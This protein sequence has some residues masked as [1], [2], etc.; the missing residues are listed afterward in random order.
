M[1]WLVVVYLNPQVMI[2]CIMLS[3]AML[4]GATASRWGLERDT[5]AISSNQGVRLAANL[6]FCPSS[7]RNASTARW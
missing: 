7:P 6:H 2:R 5:L 1:L 3:T 4:E